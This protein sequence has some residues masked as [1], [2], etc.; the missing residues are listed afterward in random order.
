MQL[1]LDIKDAGGGLRVWGADPF[2]AASWEVGPLVFREWWWALDAGIVR[3]SNQLR[4]QRGADVLRF[5]EV[6]E[7]DA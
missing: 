5:S 3:R 1:M 6:E 4:A 7:L 2:D